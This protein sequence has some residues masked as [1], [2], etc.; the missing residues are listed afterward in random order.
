[1]IANWL[2]NIFQVTP[3][4]LPRLSSVFIAPPRIFI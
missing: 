1:V 3:N 2:E 4:I